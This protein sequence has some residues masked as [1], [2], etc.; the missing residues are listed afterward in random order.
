MTALTIRS[1][2]KIHRKLK[3]IAATCG[4]SLNTLI[5]KLFEQ[6][7]DRWEAQ[8]GLLQPLDDNSPK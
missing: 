6:E 2:D 5:Q 7:V 8:H 4:I 1:D 3:I